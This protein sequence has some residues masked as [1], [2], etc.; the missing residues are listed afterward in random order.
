MCNNMLQYGHAYAFAR[1][2]GKKTISMRFAYKYQYFKICHTPWHNFF[3]YAIA[4]FL[5][6][7]HLLPVLS[8]NLDAPYSIMEKELLAANWAI[9]EGWGVRFYDLFLKYRSEIADLFA[10]LPEIVKAADEKIHPSEDFRLGIHIR[11]GDYARHLGG[12]YFYDDETYIR[13]ARQ[14]ANKH[15]NVGIYICSNDSSLNR[16]A[17]IDAFPARNVHFPQGN[18]GEDLC[19]LS[20]MD[21]LIG[22]PSTFS[23]VASMY[24]KT[25]I[26]LIE[27][28]DADVDF[29]HFEDYFVYDDKREK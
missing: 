27:D 11:R 5:G 28:K 21:A 22:P 23:L 13:I 24:N 8:Y 26:Y 29:K 7:L 16:Q 20:K 3:T 10:F 14:V 25:P 1:E 9:V 19:L 12:R 18:P 4:K 6:K 2:H 17:Y 15:D